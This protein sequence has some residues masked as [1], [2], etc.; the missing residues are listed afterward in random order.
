VM[1]MATTVV[2]VTLS[3]TNLVE[4]ATFR[5]DFEKAQAVLFSCFSKTS[6]THISNHSYHISIECPTSYIQRLIPHFY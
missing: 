3:V 2:M 1:V 5:L 4:E 6:R